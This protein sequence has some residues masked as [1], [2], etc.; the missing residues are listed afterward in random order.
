MP[1]ISSLRASRCDSRLPCWL[2]VS[3]RF[4][5][6]SIFE[7]LIGRSRQ[8]RL[9]FTIVVSD[10]TSAKEKTKKSVNYCNP[11]PGLL[12]TESIFGSG[13]DEGRGF[14]DFIFKFTALTLPTVELVSSF[15]NNRIRGLNRALKNTLT[16]CFIYFA[17]IG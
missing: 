6:S 7:K 8:P 11:P 3:Q 15:S 14:A 2:V 10:S 13:N 12:N 4:L 5:M 16:L 9:A 17:C 1:A